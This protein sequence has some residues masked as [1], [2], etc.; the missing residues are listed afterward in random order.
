M[1]VRSLDRDHLEVVR[2]V[3]IPRATALYCQLAIQRGCMVFV[4][5]SRGHRWRSSVSV[6]L[7]NLSGLPDEP[8][9]SILV[10]A[11]RL[12]GCGGDEVAK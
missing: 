2:G 9:R 4:P 6:K 10:R 12:A 5:L 3:K 11:K 8:M 7:Y 1:A